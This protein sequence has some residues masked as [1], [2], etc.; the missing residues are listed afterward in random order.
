[1]KV[2]SSI[3]KK[4]VSTGVSYW[5]PSFKME[6][7]SLCVYFFLFNSKGKLRNPVFSNILNWNVIDFKI[8]LLFLTVFNFQFNIR[9][10]LRNPIIGQCF[11]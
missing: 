7:L 6:Q 2:S 4:L 9:G 8:E 11:N 3:K 1:M 5:G 10:N